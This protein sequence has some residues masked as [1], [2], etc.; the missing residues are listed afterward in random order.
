M[1]RSTSF[2][3]DCHVARNG[4]EEQTPSLNVEVFGELKA[5]LVPFSLSRTPLS[6]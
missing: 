4:N 5:L 6:R 2:I 1:F 3:R